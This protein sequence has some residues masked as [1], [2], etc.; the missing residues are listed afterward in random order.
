M[1]MELQKLNF[2]YDN[3][4]LAKNESDPISLSDISKER[5]ITNVKK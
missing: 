3:E 1:K 2:S 4:F 5:R